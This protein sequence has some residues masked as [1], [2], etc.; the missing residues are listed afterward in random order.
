MTTTVATDFHVLAKPTGAVCNLD[1]RYC[2]FCEV[3]QCAVTNQK[4]INV[5]RG[6]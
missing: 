3:Q 6:G 5:K 4:M 2:F 1:C